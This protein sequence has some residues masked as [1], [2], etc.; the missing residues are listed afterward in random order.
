MERIGLSLAR[1]VYLLDDRR[2]RFIF[3]G[4]RGLQ[5]FLT[6]R[7]ELDVMAV[8]ILLDRGQEGVEVQVRAGSKGVG[9]PVHE[10]GHRLFIHVLARHAEACASGIAEVDPQS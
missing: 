9:Q 8:G 10:V 2:G 6:L 3:D 5:E 7:G 1:L 4:Q